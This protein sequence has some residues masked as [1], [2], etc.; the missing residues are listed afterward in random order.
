[1]AHDAFGTLK[2]KDA[3]GVILYEE[4]GRYNVLAIIDRAKADKDAGDVLGIGTRGIPIVESFEK[5]LKLKPEALIL[6]V[7]P[8]GGR[9]PDEWREN[10]KSA[11]RNGMDII[12][13]LYQFLNDDP[14]FSNLAKEYGVRSITQ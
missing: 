14:E 2:G 8:P 7:A 3:N 6:G 13:G 10:I 12:N 11:I 9:L 5:A 1:L 4:E